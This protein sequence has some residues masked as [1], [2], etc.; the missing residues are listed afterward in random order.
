[1]AD[2]NKSRTQASGFLGAIGDMNPNY[3]FDPNAGF[4][5]FLAQFPALQNVIKN[6]VGTL[7]S[8]DAVKA[9]Q[10]GALRSVASKL[11]GASAGSGAFARAASEGLSA[12]LFQIQAQNEA[13]RSNAMN[14]GINNLL[15]LTNQNEMNRVNTERSLFS[16]KLDALTKGFQGALGLADSSGNSQGQLLSSLGNLMGIGGQLAAPEWWQPTYVQDPNYFSAKDIFGSLLGLGSG[17]ANLATGGGT[18]G[19]MSLLSGLF[20]QGQGQ[21]G[22]PQTNNGGKVWNYIPNAEGYRAA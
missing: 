17:A 8:D 20:G 1:M 21:G 15:G 14:S 13:E 11:P 9:L 5:S 10:A 3:S 19:I 18:G 2:A 6:S 4:N 22:G 7:A 16:D 12:P